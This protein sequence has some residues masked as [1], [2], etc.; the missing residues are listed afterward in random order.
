MENHRCHDY[1]NLVAR[2]RQVARTCGLKLTA[3]AESSG[4]PVYQLQTRDHSSGGLYVSA[5]IHG[6]EPAG[7]EGLITWAEQFLAPLLRGKQPLPLVLLPCLN[8]WGLVNNRRSDEAGNDLNRLFN[9]DDFS[10]IAELKQLLKGQQFAL[11]LHLHEDYDAQGNYL[12]ELCKEPSG[13]GHDL[14]GRPAAPRCPSIHA[15]GSTGAR[16]SGESGNGGM[17]GVFRSTPEAVHLYQHHCPRVITFETPSE[18]G[19][20]SRVQAHVLLLRVCVRRLQAA[21]RLS[22]VS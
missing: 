13:W 21:S 14:F 4:Y 7:S 22:A 10:P 5:G 20:K 12:Y 17:S 2:W 6:D 1:R 3:F 18:E 16:S 9:R 19:L 15:D 11:A 8:P